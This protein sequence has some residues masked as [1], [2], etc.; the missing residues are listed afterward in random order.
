VTYAN[1]TTDILPVAPAPPSLFRI[2]DDATHAELVDAKK[3]H[4]GDAVLLAALYARAG[5]E[6][7]ALD[8][9]DRAS[10][11]DARVRTLREHIRN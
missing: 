5:L 11:N 2:T 6:R 8:A 3:E 1:G 7:E 4:P 9:L 10:T